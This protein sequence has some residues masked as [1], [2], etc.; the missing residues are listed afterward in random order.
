MRKFFENQFQNMFL[1]SPFL[2]A[3]G[4]ALYFGLPFEPGIPPAAMICGLALFL[5]AA[6]A[7]RIPAP[8]RVVAIFLF[9]FMY[10]AAF[11]QIFA[12]PQISRTMRDLEIS[13]RVTAIDFG[14]EK[15]R[16]YI[17]T[18][19]VAMDE[20]TAMVRLSLPENAPDAAVGDDVRVKCTLFRPAG[21]YAPGTFDFARWA[22][23]NGITATGYASEI[24]IL[25]HIDTGMISNMRQYLHRTTN[26]FLF[27]SL[28]LGFKQSV[29]QPEAEVWTA[30]GVGHVWSISGFHMTLVSGWLFAV[31]Y[32]IFRCIPFVTRRIPARIPAMICAAVGLALYLFLSGAGVATIRAFIM[33]ALVFAAFILGRNAFSMRNVCIAFMIVFFMNP[34]YVMQAGFQLSFSAVFGLVW[35]W[36]VVKPKMPGNK[37]MKILCGAMA[38]SLVATIFTMPFVAVHFYAFPLYGLL[39]NLVLLPIFSFIIMP[40]VIIGAFTSTI[41]VTF[42]ITISHAVYDFALSMAQKIATMPFASVAM[43]HISNTALVLSIIGFVCLILVRD[44]RRPIKYAIFG[45]FEFL[46]IIVIAATPRPV[47]FASPDHELVAFRTGDKIEFNKSRASNHYFAFDTWKQISNIRTDAPN[48]RRKH[49]KGLYLFKTENF[50]LAY[51][52]KFVPLR[53]NITKLCRDDDTDY[54]VSYFDVSSPTCDPKILRGPVLIYSSGRVV[55]IPHSRPWH[56][57]RQ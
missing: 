56:N 57:P 51:V 17:N 54:I 42:P 46:A 45:A 32:L 44:T 28:V 47:F 52:Q 10:A 48:T 13:G 3:F 16:I 35:F 4:A 5:V 30:A 43:P 6:I 20:K 7:P 11:T 41:G 49:K 34:H 37:I 36:G 23:F 39:G 55:R 38:T 1:W 40:L 18:T 27:D 24:S 21:A 9:G 53:A 25:S 22:Y 50:N 33:T 2:M 8:P 15:S 26:S 19:G 29:P 12:T 14:P 31:F